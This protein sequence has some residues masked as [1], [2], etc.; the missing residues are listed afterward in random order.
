MGTT[1]TVK[2]VAPPAGV[3]AHDVRAAVD[4]VLGHIDREMSTY[5]DDSAI[6]RFN[7]SRDTRWID[8]P[9]DLAAVVQAA[10]Q[11]SADSRGAFDVTVAPLV[12]AWGFGPAATPAWSPDEGALAAV[13]A[14]TGY[15]KLHVRTDPPA[16][17]KE[18]PHL[19]VDLNGI[20]PGFAVDVLAERF[21]SMGAVNFMIELGGEVRARGR[22]AKGEAWRVAVERP[23]GGAPTPYA[24]VALDDMATT[25]SGEYRHYYIRDGRRYSHTID[26]RTGW[27][28]SHELAS[29]VVIGADAM[30]A[31]AWAT[32]YNVLGPE[33][34]F[35]L[36]MKL[37]MPAMFIERRGGA[38][39]HRATPAFEPFL[40][41]NGNE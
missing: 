18:S 14:A 3:E 24:I 19:A 31:D 17:R 28:I 6:S 30:H 5:R 15:R 22:N 23:D 20:A 33:E 25:T 26:P 8:V 35:D 41:K 39:I 13:R 16:L 34:G 4:E 1:Y 32:A 12:Q 7:L 29:V 36:A 11:V 2:M 21:S 37:G 27:P 40:V 10:L 9:A 38:L